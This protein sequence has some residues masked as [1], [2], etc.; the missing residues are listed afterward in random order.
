VRRSIGI[1]AVALV[2]A[3][4]VWAWT[5]NHSGAKAQDRVSTS[6]NTL[7]LTMNATMLPV[8]QFDTH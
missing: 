4:A 5:L 3:A 7:N 2:A 6:I 8:Q 1:I